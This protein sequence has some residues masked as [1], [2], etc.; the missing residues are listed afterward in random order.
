MEGWAAGKGEQRL[1][2]RH[3]QIE[4]RRRHAQEELLPAGI[5]RHHHIERG[6][7]LDQRAQGERPVIIRF[8]GALH[9]S[10]IMI[11]ILEGVGHLMDESDLLLD[12]IEGARWPAG[13]SFL[14]QI[15]AALLWIVE[16]GHL[17]GVQL[18]KALLQVEVGGDEAEGGHGELFREDPLV[19]K[20]FRQAL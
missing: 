12:G 20:L 1:D 19:R 11:L 2:Q 7:P 15:E 8:G 14:H 3:R 9:R 13:L 6:F 4:E 18:E 10:E 16:A 5:H 17:L